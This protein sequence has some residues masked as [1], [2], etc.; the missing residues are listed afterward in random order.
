M[1]FK[2]YLSGPITGLSFDDAINWTD[3]AK[4]ELA[5][6]DINGYRP[7]RGKKKLL[8]DIKELSAQGYLHT[9]ISNPKAIVA[10]DSYDVFSSDCLLVNLLDAKRVSI[11]TC[12][13]MAWAWQARK[14]IVLVME[15]QGNIHDH[16]FVTECCSYHVETLDEGTHIVNLILNDND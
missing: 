4:K 6:Y 14:P 13:E 3:Y 11:G 9:S 16:G 10:R 12:Y 8:G 2:A 15:K 5:K 7:L 1:K